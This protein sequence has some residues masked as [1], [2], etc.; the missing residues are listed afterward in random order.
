MDGMN[1]PEPLRI[2][3]VGIRYGMTHDGK[4]VAWL[5]PAM[6]AAAAELLRT[7][8][9]M[10]A[11]AESMQAMYHAAENE[12]WEAAAPGRVITHA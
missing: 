7:M 10:N 4:S 5:P 9:Q 1:R 11:A 6:W 2:V 8:V 12:A 3:H